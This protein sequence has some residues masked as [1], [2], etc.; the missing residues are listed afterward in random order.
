MMRKTIP[1]YKNKLVSDLQVA[2]SQAYPYLRLDVFEASRDRPRLSRKVKLNRTVSLDKTGMISEGDINI[3]E[4]MTVGE[5]ENLLQEKFGITA[6]V[7]RKSG[8]LWLE[9]TMTNSW[10]L[11]QQ[12]EHGRELSEPYKNM[13]DEIDYT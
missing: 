8:S 3:P 9:T 10:T 6:Q 7:S 12:N 13:S 2:F 1:V 11:Q 4:S 5:L